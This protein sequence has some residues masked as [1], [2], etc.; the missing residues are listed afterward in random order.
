MAKCWFDNLTDWFR[1][2]GSALIRKS[3]DW[4]G[5][6]ERPQKHLSC[7]L[8]DHL[9]SGDWSEVRY[10]P[11]RNMTIAGYTTEV[12]WHDFKW[13]LPSTIASP[14]INH[15][16]MCYSILR[17]QHDI[18]INNLFTIFWKDLLCFSFKVLFRDLHACFCL[19]LSPT[20]G[21]Y[22]NTSNLHEV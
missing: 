15:D 10:V 11:F 6:R 4:T 7:V 3:E 1:I 5:W 2:D 18:K 13:P 12:W 16:M 17:E 19:D 8:Y 21:L 14:Y 9:W 20:S 22:C